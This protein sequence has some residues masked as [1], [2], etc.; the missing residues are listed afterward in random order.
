VTTNG[1]QHTRQPV[2]AA[3][4]SRLVGGANS[5]QQTANRH[6]DSAAKGQAMS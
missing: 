6:P 4:H 2:A 5:R 3:A 1:N